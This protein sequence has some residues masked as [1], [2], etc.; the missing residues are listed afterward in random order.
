MTLAYL[1]SDIIPMMFSL[2]IFRPNKTSI[3]NINSGILIG[4]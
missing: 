3:K 4:R 2:L 1:L